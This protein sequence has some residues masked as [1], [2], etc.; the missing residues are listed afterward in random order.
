M[1]NERYSAQNLR[2]PIKVPEQ[3]HQTDGKQTVFQRSAPD[4]M[5]HEAVLKSS[6][7]FDRTH[8][9]AYATLSLHKGAIRAL[10]RRVD[11]RVVLRAV[12]DFRHHHGLNLLLLVR[13][14]QQLFGL[15]V[16]H[17]QQAVVVP[18]DQVAGLDDHAIDGDGHVDL[19]RA[20]LV[21]AAVGD[22][23]GEDREAVLAQHSAVADGAVNDD[24]G[25]A[26]ELGLADHDLAD[27]GVGEVAASVHHDH[28]T[29][30]GELQG[31]MDQQVVA[32]P[33]LDGEGGP[34]HGRAVMH[35]AQARAAGRHPRHAVAD[36]GHGHLQELL[37]QL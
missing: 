6:L 10:Q 2:P 34:G 33:G 21:G 24:A 36:V 26:L 7:D 12:A 31:L 14:R 32:R 1:I 22:A 30:L 13:G 20:V 37:G 28:V 25:K 11:P 27:E 15:F 9:S 17:A 29:G 8:V 19:A 35:G 4:S 23:C 3:L 16:G 5:P 18:D